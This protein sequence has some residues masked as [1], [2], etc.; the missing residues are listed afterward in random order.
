MP[1]RSREEIVA[2]VLEA[3]LSPSNKTT[4]MYKARLS[5]TQLCYYFGVLL[6]RELIAKRKD[7]MWII[8]E[9][10][11]E[12]IAAYTRIKEIIESDSTIQVLR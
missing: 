2:S 5:Y 7:G 10:G 9:K 3:L 8:T 12:Y 11:R 6:D 1:N 4:A